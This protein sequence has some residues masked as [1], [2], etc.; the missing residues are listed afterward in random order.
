MS[1]KDFLNAMSRPH[2]QPTKAMLWYC[3]QSSQMTL[4]YSLSSEPPSY[5]RMT[6]TEKS[7]AG[8]TVNHFLFNI[9]SFKK[10]ITLACQS[11]QCTA[12]RGIHRWFWT[13]QW[14]ATEESLE[15]HRSSGSWWRVRERRGEATVVINWH[16]LDIITDDY[17]LGH[18]QVPSTVHRA[19][20]ILFFHYSCGGW[21]QGQR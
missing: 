13:S 9:P 18:Y 5:S 21:R 3:L 12:G 15:H 10:F 19:F 6:P 8:K 2:P 11:S 4:S 16:I 17:R 20:H 7:G 1:E 14:G